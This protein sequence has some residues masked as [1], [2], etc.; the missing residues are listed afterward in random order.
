M[1]IAVAASTFHLSPLEPDGLRGP[2]LYRF[3]DFCKFASRR[4]E[5][6]TTPA[7][8]L[9]HCSQKVLLAAGEEAHGPS[10]PVD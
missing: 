6:E 4:R 10:S 2:G 5:L 1:V 9:L 3:M 7:H 8:T